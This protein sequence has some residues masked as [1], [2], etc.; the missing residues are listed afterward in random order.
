MG[1]TINEECM[2]HFWLT[3]IIVL[4]L[5]SSDKLKVL[6]KDLKKENIKIGKMRDERIFY[7]T[8]LPQVE[9]GTTSISKE[10]KVS[11]IQNFPS[12]KFVSDQ[13]KSMQSALLFSYS[14]GENRWSQAFYWGHQC[15]MKPKKSGQGF[16]INSLIPFS[17]MITIMLSVPHYVAVVNGKQHIGMD[18][19]KDIR[20]ISIQ[21][22]RGA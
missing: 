14:W 10:S 2:N 5:E 7:P 16:E 6:L 1:S 20:G 19:I 8:S 21:H 3:S 12:L 18:R 15:K 22:V 11:W 9:C 4:I 13:N 17:T